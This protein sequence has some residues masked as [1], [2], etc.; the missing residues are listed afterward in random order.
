MNPTPVRKA[1]HLEFTKASN[2]DVKPLMWIWKNRLPL[3]KLSLL[4]GDPGLGKTLVSNDIIARITT[5]RDY[6]DKET[7]SQGACAILA[8]EDDAADTIVPRLLAAG[9]DISHVILLGDVIE[10]SGRF[11][12]YSLQNIELLEDAL[13]TVVNL[14]L[15][16]IDPLK[17][18]CSGVDTHNNADTRA[19]LAP[20]TQM[21]ARLNI[22]VVGIEHLNKS[23]SDTP[24][25]R[26]SGSIAFVA[27]ARSAY[28]ITKDQDDPSRRLMLP[29]KS[30]LSKEISGLAYKVEEQNGF[31]IVVW[32]NEP[33]VQSAEEAFSTDDQIDRRYAVDEAKDILIE[34]L[35]DGA[36]K[37]SDI[38]KTTRSQ[39]I[40]D[41]TIK[42]AARKLG[43]ESIPNGR[44]SIWQLP[45][46]L[47]TK[48]N[49][50]RFGSPLPT[51]ETNEPSEPC[52]PSDPN[53]A[54]N[55]VHLGHM[56]HSVHI[57]QPDM[58]LARINIHN[59][60]MD[61][62]V[63][64]DDFIGNLDQD[65]LEDIAC[66]RLDRNAIRTVAKTFYPEMGLQ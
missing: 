23:G 25:H 42:R 4:G 5:G 30:N 32:E 52:E 57:G 28:A 53:Q 40:T 2:I 1:R 22:A 64:L 50:E 16:V 39:D 62:D 35:A 18:Y 12:T 10:P 26:I 56:V 33:V 15:L 63:D 46:A 17:Q 51:D 58:S 20:L 43:I 37:R 8:S 34:L 55:T 11:S 65:G 31:P 21:A 45:A 14:K 13:K 29:L 7:C 6:P 54:T 49:S 44:E 9:A 38:F 41:S 60:L 24:L 27:A 47:I 59:A 3:G 36:K 19:I 61:T 48:L 66:G